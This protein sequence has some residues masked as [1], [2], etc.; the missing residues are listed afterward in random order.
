V[1]INSRKSALRDRAYKDVAAAL[2]AR[3]GEEAR[4]V[5]RAVPV[6]PRFARLLPELVLGITPEQ[7][8]TIAARAMQPK[9]PP[10]VGLEHLHAPA[11]SVREQAALL[12]DRLRRT[13]SA[14]FRVLIADAEETIVIVARFL[15][16]LELFRE[17]A[18]AFDQAAPL[19]DLTVRWT[20]A[21]DGTVEVDDEFDGAGADGDDD[22]DD[23]GAPAAATGQDGERDGAAAD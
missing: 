12:V 20:G 4:R 23:D 18:V 8:A 10:T 3:M 22:G 6:E 14:S 17:G 11:V 19:A 7:L 15:A 16:L 21:D 1:L 5:P 13:R 2:A 9:P